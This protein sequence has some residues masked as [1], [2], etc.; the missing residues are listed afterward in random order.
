MDSGG[1]QT[2]DS[3]IPNVDSESK[4]KDLDRISDLEYDINSLQSG[5]RSLA[6]GVVLIVFSMGAGVAMVT[7]GATQKIACAV[8]RV[9]DCAGDGLVMAGWTVFGL[10]TLVG[11]AL[12]V[13]ATT[14]S[15]S[16]D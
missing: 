7:L 15:N 11:L 12:V 8:S 4:S 1:P 2:S 6:W 14:R 9:T 5:L 13:G 10:G 3:R 16:K